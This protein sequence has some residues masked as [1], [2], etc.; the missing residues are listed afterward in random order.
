[1]VPATMAVNSAVPGERAILALVMA[2]AQN[3]GPATVA[4][5]CVF[6][7]ARAG[8]AIANAVLAAALV[9][10]Q[11]HVIRITGNNSPMA[12]GHLD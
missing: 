12:V 9:R 7:K 10:T 4:A 8:S 2:D 6:I 5:M 11:P 1:M 3:S